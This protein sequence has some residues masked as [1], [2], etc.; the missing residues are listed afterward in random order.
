MEPEVSICCSNK[1]KKCRCL[2]II[3]AILV[4]LFAFTLG[5]IIGALTSILS[6]I[7]ASYFLAIL[8]VLALLT[9]LTII[10]IICNCRNQRCF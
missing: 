7:G 6:L 1:D 3:L 2:Y 5:V 4:T 10:F 8:T 9:I